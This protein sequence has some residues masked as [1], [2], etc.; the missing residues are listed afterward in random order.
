MRK[1]KFSRDLFIVSILTLVTV[2]TW[3]VL[4]TYRVFNRREIPKV[5]QEQIEPLDPNLD[6][7]IFDNL[8]ERLSVK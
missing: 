4:D 8:S 1:R 7:K 5:L 3:I 2:L 6:I